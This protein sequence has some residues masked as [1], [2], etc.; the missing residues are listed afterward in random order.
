MHAECGMLFYPGTLDDQNS[1]WLQLSR[2]VISRKG[3][4]RD[5]SP[6][7]QIKRSPSA[8]FSFLLPFFEPTLRGVFGFLLPSA[9]DKDG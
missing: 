9:T 1:L 6:G 8:T 5:L 4:R 2:S 7:A 3:I